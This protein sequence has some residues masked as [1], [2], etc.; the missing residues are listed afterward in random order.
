MVKEIKPV[1]ELFV[2]ELLE[3]KAKKYGEESLTHNEQLVLAHA[4]A[5]EK[6][7]AT[8]KLEKELK[9]VLPE[10]V[11]IK[12]LDTMPKHIDTLRAILLS[13][14][15]TDENKINEVMELLKGG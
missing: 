9:K 1:S 13:Y 4:K 15:I 11:A 3:K 10:E 6:I 7:G 5:I 2:K 14:G 8:G 12:V